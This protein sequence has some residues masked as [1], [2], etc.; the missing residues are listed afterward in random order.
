MRSKRRRGRPGRRSTRPARTRE[1]GTLPC[2]VDGRADRWTRRCDQLLCLRV[3]GDRGRVRGRCRRRPH[4]G[5]RRRRRCAVVLLRVRLPDLGLERRRS[6]CGGEH[7]GHE[8]R[9]DDRDH[10]DAREHSAADGADRDGNRG[11]GRNRARVSGGCSEVP[12]AG[13]ES[14]H[15]C[16]DRDRECRTDVPELGASAPARRTTGKMRVGACSVARSEVGARVVAEARERPLAL[17][18]R[19]RILQVGLDPFRTQRLACAMRKGGDAVR[20]HAEEGEICCGVIR[21]T[22]VYFRAPPAGAP[23]VPRTRGGSVA[24]RGCARPDRA[25]WRGLAAT[26]E[27]VERVRAPFDHA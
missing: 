9:G 4:G 15:G 25:R 10:R 6:L 11:A 18:G 12:D 24:T 13:A 26:I 23:A 16:Q 20:G 19:R 17:A 22:S 1:A 14:D 3:G 2:L 21:S 7:R 5:A 8:H 27:V